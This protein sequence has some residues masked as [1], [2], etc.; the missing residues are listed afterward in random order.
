[1]V[2]MAKPLANGY[3]IGAVLLRD[4]VATMTAGNDAKTQRFH[5]LTYSPRIP[6]HNLRWI[7]I[8]VCLG[9]PCSLPCI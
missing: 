3:P 6:R 9:L 7:A 2:T 1:M 8:G 5:C 4:S